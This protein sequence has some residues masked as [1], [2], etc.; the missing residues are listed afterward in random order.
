MNKS[1]KHIE[2][3]IAV[4]QETIKTIN[5]GGNEKETLKN[6]NK[7]LDK[8]LANLVKEFGGESFFYKGNNS[9]SWQLAMGEVE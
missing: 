5:E 8:N 2:A 6:F 1:V 4:A 3:I 9:V 7:S